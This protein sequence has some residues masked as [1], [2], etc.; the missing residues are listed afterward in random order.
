[1][2]YVACSSNKVE[3]YPVL[4]TMRNLRRLERCDHRDSGCFCPEDLA[5]L[6]GPD[7]AKITPRGLCLPCARAGRL[8]ESEGNCGQR[9]RCAKIDIAAE[10]TTKSKKRSHATMVESEQ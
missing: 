7:I 2:Q 1:M 4:T 9:E 6:F 5:N 3:S 10:D 8:L